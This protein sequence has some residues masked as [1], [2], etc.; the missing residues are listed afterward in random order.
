MGDIGGYSLNCHKHINTGEGGVLVTNNSYFAKRMKLLRNHAENYQSFRKKKELNN[1]IGFNFRM[2]EL[3]A[4]IGIEQ[5]KKLK[6]IISKRNK[7]IKI[8][9]NKIKFLNG[10]YVPK[11]ENILDHNFYIFPITLDL[12]KIKYDR[13]HIIKCLSREGIQGLNEGYINIHNLPMFKNKIAYGKNG[14]PWSEYNKDIDYGKN[15]C[16]VAEN[17][18]KKTF[19]GFEVCLFKL[20]TKDVLNISKAFIKVWKCLKI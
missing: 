19:I 6:K 4:A 18:H 13:K 2:G 10:I 3:E 5:Y 9:L 20:S 12:K 11:L 15:L 1:M 7:L 16:P 14:F 8:L 17:L